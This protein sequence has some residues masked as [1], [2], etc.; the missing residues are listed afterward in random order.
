MKAISDITKEEQNMEKPAMQKSEGAGRLA[1][2]EWR[3]AGKAAQEAAHHPSTRAVS[4]KGDEAA[5]RAVE[6][7]KA[8]PTDDL[9]RK[10]MVGSQQ[11]RR[12]HH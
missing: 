9:S 8:R 2:S 12:F 4:P 1:E 10:G 5:L 3:L 6:W 11:D 7:A